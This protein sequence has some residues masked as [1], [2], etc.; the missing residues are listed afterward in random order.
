[1]TSS[2]GDDPAR[3]VDVEHAVQRRKD[4]EEL[5]WRIYLEKML[6]QRGDDVPSIE[7]FLHRPAW[8]ARAACRGMG[9]DQ[10]FPARG[11]HIDNARAICD[12][13][14]VRSECLDA[15]I[16]NID[17]HGIWGGTSERERR[18]I[19]RD[20]GIDDEKVA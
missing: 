9:T 14:P 17:R 2:E 11:E 16:E 6:R 18:R 15:A 8:H 4:A 12:S 7:D 3:R 10:F 13:C 5:A 19:R 1:M 20:R